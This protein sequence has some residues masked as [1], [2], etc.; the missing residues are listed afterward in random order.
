[1]DGRF[2]ALRVRVTVRHLST[3]LKPAL[4][5]VPVVLGPRACI[6]LLLSV[7]LDASNVLLR[8]TKISR[9]QRIRRSCCTRVSAR[10]KEPK[11]K[12]GGG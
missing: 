7:A 4:G 6:P 12:G 3:E 11:K 9:A 10:R 8:T 5:H 2:V 1:M